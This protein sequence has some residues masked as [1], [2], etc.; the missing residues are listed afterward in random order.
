MKDLMALNQ[1]FMAL[2][3]IRSHHSNPDS[4]KSKHQQ[5]LGE[6]FNIGASFRI[7]TKEVN[8]STEPAKSTPT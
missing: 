2:G 5:E 6:T 3:F 4:L 1:R 8:Q 7:A